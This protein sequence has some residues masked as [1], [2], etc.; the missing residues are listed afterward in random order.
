MCP[1]LV[2]FIFLFA[3]LSHPKI[4]KREIENNTSNKTHK[5][6]EQKHMSMVCT[7]RSSSLSFPDEPDEKILNNVMPPPPLRTRRQTRGKRK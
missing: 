7:N 5:N 4:K 3:F 1:S 2:H 6:G